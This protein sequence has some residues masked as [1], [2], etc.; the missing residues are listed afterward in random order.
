MNLEKMEFIND[1]VIYSRGEEVSKYS[2][3]DEVSLIEN[4]SDALVKVIVMNGESKGTFV[5]VDK[6]LLKS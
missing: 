5:T 2:S 3:G 4:I 6:V 1:G